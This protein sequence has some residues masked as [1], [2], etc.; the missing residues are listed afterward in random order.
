MSVESAIDYLLS[1]LKSISQNYRNQASSLLQEADDV[2]AT[3]KPQ[4]VGSLSYDP[5]GADSIFTR[6]P[7]PPNIS[8]LSAWQPPSASALQAVDQPSEDFSGDVPV[9]AFPTFNY[10]ELPDLSNFTEHSPEL[11]SLQLT[12][13]LPDDYEATAPELRTVKTIDIPDSG[14]IND[15]DFPSDPNIDFKSLPSDINFYQKYRDGTALIAPSLKEFNSKLLEL[16]DELFPIEG[17][18]INQ[19]LNTLI[20]NE[21]GRKFKDVEIEDIDTEHDW[22]GEKY[23]Q[24]RQPI[25]EKR[26]VALDTLDAQ[27]SSITGL[28][29]GIRQYTQ[30]FSEI[31]TLQETFQVAEKVAEARQEEEIQHLKKVMELVPKTVTACLEF[32]GQEIGWRIQEFNLALEGAQG[33]LELALK[34]LDFKRKELVFFV[35][36]NEIQIKKFEL[37]VQV[38]KNQL[39]SVKLFVANNSLLAEYNQHQQQCYEAAQSFLEARLSRYQTQIDW[40]KVDIEQR[41]TALMGFEAEFMAYQANIKIHQAN[42]SALQARIKGDLALAD[43]ELA[44]VQLYRAELTTQ[45]AQI[46]IQEAKVSAQAAT[47]RASLDEYDTKVSGLLSYLRMLDQNVYTFLQAII[48][49]FN[50]ETAAQEIDLSNQHLEDQR[51]LHEASS[52]LQR[53]WLSLMLD[54]QKHSIDLQQLE[55]QSAIMDSGAATLSNIASTAFSGLNAIG[56]REIIEEA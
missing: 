47:N 45:I 44:K 37:K 1:N 54:S 25:M 5:S 6:I 35:R 26:F 36:Y 16:R 52:Q 27:S 39:E 24:N 30:I 23:N 32:M 17:V 56:T 51:I 28:P 48:K 18:F 12:P 20:G 50:A 55:S 22:E 49:G 14:S 19:L 40:L 42:Q 2:L 10:D 9:L 29:T 33:T 34:V 4:E 21:N 11:E 46:K 31:K 3:L 15:L 8:D 41:K 38:V 43:S 13:E 53:D 7:Q